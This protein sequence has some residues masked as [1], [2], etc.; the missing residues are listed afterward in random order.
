[1]RLVLLMSAEGEIVTV[2]KKGQATI[3]KK[4]REKFGIKRKAL[5]V[6]T[7]EGILIRPIPDPSKERGSLK[8]LFRGKSAKKLVEEA[9]KEE[10]MREKRLRERYTK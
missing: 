6:G 1:M 3:P 2:T 9:R 8:E 5:V 10:R 7:K 4:L